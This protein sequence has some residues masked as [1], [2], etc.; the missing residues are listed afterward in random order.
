MDESENGQHA[1]DSDR[2]RDGEKHYKT[3]QTHSDGD[4]TE[5]I[6]DLRM[7]RRG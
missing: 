2:D 6:E 3:Q 7:I 4:E 1:G 5:E